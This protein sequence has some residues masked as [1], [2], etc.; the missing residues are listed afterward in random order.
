MSE[1]HKITVLG[2]GSFGTAIANMIASNGHSVTLWMRDE[3]NAE[4][5]RKTGENSPYLP[6]YKL[7]KNL[8][9]TSDLIS[10]L[11]GSDIV[12]FSIPSKAFRD[13]AQQATSYIK[14]G[15]V[16]ISTT[17]GVESNTYKLMS[18]ILGEELNNVDIGVISGPNLAKEI[19]QNQITATVVAC[20]NQDSAKLIQRLLSTQYFRVYTNT[21]RYGVELAGALKNI[22]AIMAGLLTA[23]GVGDNTKSVLITRSLAEM[24][25]FA[26]HLGANPMTFLGLS[27][28]GDLFVTCTSPLSRNYQVGYAIG[29]GKTL[30]QIIAE[31]GQV[32]EGVNTTRIVKEK[33]DELGIYMPLANALYELLFNQKPIK[34]LVTGMMLAEHAEDVEFSPKL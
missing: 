7:S 1:Q 24:S 34:E 9:V 6:G 21:D 32:A 19:V 16:V 28:V 25:R 11:E 27:G 18:Q 26:V 33:S 23:L 10:S 14:P 2:G 22:Y 20:E 3:E 5:T 30:D 15:S 8:Q 4:N 12:F 29:Q 13:V 17:K 31:L